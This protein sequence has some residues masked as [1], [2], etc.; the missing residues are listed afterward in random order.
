MLSSKKGGLIDCL[1]WKYAYLTSSWTKVYEEHK[2]IFAQYICIFVSQNCISLCVLGFAMMMMII[3]IIILKYSFYCAL[4]YVRIY[5]LNENVR[6]IFKILLILLVL[7]HFDVLH[8]IKGK[9]HPQL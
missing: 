9:M 8:A 7:V 2:T 4:L 5:F 3:M 1:L 6:E